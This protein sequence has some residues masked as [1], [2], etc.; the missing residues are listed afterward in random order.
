LYLETIRGLLLTVAA[1]GALLYAAHLAARRWWPSAGAATRLAATGVI[2]VALALAIFYPLALAGLF[3]PQ[4]ATLAAVA[5]GVV[6]HLRRTSCG[7]FWADRHKVA[8]WLRV[9]VRSRGALLALG[10]GILLLSA[11]FRAAFHPPLSYD[12]LT[13]HDYFAGTWVQTGRMAHFAL[14]QA[15]EVAAHFPIHFEAIVAWTMLPF[16]SDFLVNFVNFPFVALLALSVY[17]LCRELGVGCEDSSLGAGL[18]CV[19]PAVLAY[20]TT[21]Y[22]DVFAAA[23]LCCAA[24]FLVRYVKGGGRADAVL[25]FLASGL[26]VGAKYSAIAPAGILCL[27]AVGV[28][29]R[30]QGPRV[31]RGLAALAMGGGI[32]AAA[33]GYP[34]ARNW[35]EVGNPMYPATVR[36]LGAEVF[37]GSPA[38][39]EL[40]ARLGRGSWRDDVRQVKRSLTYVYGMEPTP[41]SWGPKL[42]LLASLAVLALV[43]ARRAPARGP[44]WCLTLA[45]AA[46]IAL[47]YLDTSDA[48]LAVRRFWY[49]SS[50]RL[51]AAPVG[52]MAVCAMFGVSLLPQPRTRGVVRA[53]F[54]GLLLYDMC[55]MCILPDS[56]LLLPA[57]AVLLP[58]AL[59]AGLWWRGRRLRPRTARVAA[60]VLAVGLLAGGSVAVQWVRDEKRDEFYA[61]RLDLHP[62][63]RYWAAGWAFCDDPRAPKTIAL[64][65]YEPRVGHHW[66]FY[67]L[68]G[69]RLQNRVVYVYTDATRGGR[70]QMSE[71]HM[72]ADFGIWWANLQR[73]E[74]THLFMQ[75]NP[76]LPLDDRRREPV[77]M[78]WIR[79]RP[80]F[81][82][83]LDQGDHYRVYT[84][85]PS[86]SP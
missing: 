81:F 72:S 28:S 33:G 11:A 56:E 51:L 82:T 69:R 24:L 47:F 84:V 63:P 57:L 2:A 52:L 6:A 53:A 22:T 67:P 19:S 38:V 71:E 3:T 41:L 65:S 23:L 20:L 29:F 32:V 77:E 74:A 27:L 46:P 60:S 59:A 21:Q 8:G 35:I 49:D 39:A 58:A 36:L 26:A 44:L 9:V 10:V 80:D 73:A 61:T 1:N 45:W 37:P 66:F 16:H 25:V 85:V 50:Y 12:S 30:R 15:M 54:C 55:A 7:G 75:L 76:D 43:L 4:A 40:T 14:P 48:V 83:L 62:V 42:P 31:R 64:A 68:M 79:A 86:A 13:Y 5:I 34:Y 18:V 17:G 70:R 78:G